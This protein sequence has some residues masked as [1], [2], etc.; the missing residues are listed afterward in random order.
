MRAA[1]PRRP[2]ST[3]LIVG[4]LWLFLY[5]TFTLVH[6]MLLDDADSVHAEVA[7]EMLL[8]HDYVTLYA[9]GIRYLEKAPLLYWSM[10]ACMRFVQLFGHGGPRALAAASRVP[11]A[12]TVLA[13]AFV[14][15]AF[16]RRAFRSR[17]A[18]FYA[19]VILMSSPGL[20]LFTRITLPDAMLCLW[21]ALAMLCFWLLDAGAPLPMTA[22]GDAW[23]DGWEEDTPRLLC[24]G[25]AASCALAV[26]TKGLIGLV[27]PVGTAAL[28]LI[29]TRGVRGALVRVDRLHPVSSALVF[30]LI[31]APWHVWAAYDNPD[32]GVPGRIAR[33]GGHLLVPSPKPGNVHGWAWFYFINEQVLRYLNARVPRDY[34]TVPLWLFWGLCLVWLM[35]WSALLFKALGPVGH[36]LR[37]GVN[38]ISTR[39]TGSLKQ[40]WHYVRRH[41][42]S[43]AFLLLSLWAAVPLVFFSF[44]TRQEYYVL[45]ALPA[46]AVL[47]GGWLGLDGR[48]RWKPVT[49]AARLIRRSNLRCTLV[50]VALGAVFALAAMVVMIQTRSVDANADLAALLQQNPG[51]YALSMGHFLDLNVRAM[52][53]F[54]LPLAIAALSLFLGPLYSYY[55][56]RA[57]RPHAATLALAAGASGFLLAVHLALQTFAPVLS[58]AKLAEAIR[59]QL[60]PD[61]LIVIHQEYEY[62]S[63]L[64]FYLQRPSYFH[65]HQVNIALNPI[66]ILTEPQH[67]GIAD[68][69]RSANLWYGSFFPD[70]PAIFET[71][72]ALAEKWRG[73]QRIWVW[74]DLANDPA[75]LPAVLAPAY[76]IAQSGGKEI[77]SN[78]RSGEPAA[79]ASPAATPSANT[80]AGSNSHTRHRAR[81]P[82]RH[83]RR[84][85]RR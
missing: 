76:V 40:Q 75:P 81:R 31:A 8:R 4:A 3:T 71:T 48:V 38:A 49:Q 60:G 41:P 72:Q 2:I 11:L 79:A 80:V 58:S 39:D 15:E 26:L 55:L 35:P 62:G 56:R 69:G 74:Q 36:F 16:A 25:F 20:F 84:A 51:A 23:S 5:A 61:D 52:A 28:Y 33:V 17:S 30:L 85:R 78:H 43:R 12:L 57:A 54:R 45:P 46:I 77:V 53:L 24:Y 22:R 68:Y 83:T 14:V 63:T 29:A 10:A 67:S 59:P 50:L 13:L 82:A 70:A 1:P 19:A 34:D 6:P 44:S 73:P 47:M 65:A 9:N 64:G 21:I 27:F 18:G 66:H 32:R 7:R 42:V 37:R